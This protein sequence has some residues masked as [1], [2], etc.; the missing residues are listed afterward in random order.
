[1][2]IE[3]NIGKGGVKCGSQSI[4]R[5]D[6]EGLPEKEKYEQMPEGNERLSCKI[7]EEEHYRK[8][9]MVWSKTCDGS[10]V[11]I[12]AGSPLLAPS[13]ESVTQN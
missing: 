11:D 9:S 12:S 5:M 4:D 13:Q 6:M 2:V 10:T 3:D 8:C 7:P 1:M